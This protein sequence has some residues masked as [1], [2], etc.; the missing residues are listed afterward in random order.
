MI[1]FPI[2]ATNGRTET[3]ANY[4]S[5]INQQLATRLSTSKGSAMGAREY[6]GLL[7][8]CL[9]DPSTEVAFARLLY[10]TRQACRQEKSITLRS[11]RVQARKIDDGIA[12]VSIVYS[13]N[14]TSKTQ[15]LKLNM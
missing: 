1:K 13:I 15:N 7:R 6:G 10:H 3:V 5:Q 14:A 11:A 8:V 12:E 2:E 4:E 9:F